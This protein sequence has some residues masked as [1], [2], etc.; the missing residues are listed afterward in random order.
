MAS[1]DFPRPCIIG[2]GSSPSRCGPPESTKDAGALPLLSYLLDD[3]WA[4]MVKRGDGVLRLP[5]PAFDLGGV[6]I[7]RANSFLARHPDS[8]D[9]LRRIFTLKLAT[10]REDGE[11]TRRRALRSEFSDEEWRL[12]SELA[13]HPNR[14]LITATPEGG[15]TYAEGAHEAIFRRWGKRHGWIA[16]QREFL[17]W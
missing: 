17:R 14:L 9:Q 7:E 13:D 16:A 8:E 6:L 5:A 4:Q 11:P 2:Y 1:S 12:V 10:V 15:E 3:M